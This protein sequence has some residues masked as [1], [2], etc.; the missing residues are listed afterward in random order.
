[1]YTILIPEPD[2]EIK[3]QL[4]D[5]CNG[6][7][8]QKSEKP[9]A[10]PSRYCRIS[11]PKGIYNIPYSEILFIESEQKKSIIHTADHA[12]SL[13]VPLYRLQETLPKNAFIQ[14]HR[15]FIINLENTAFID[16]TKDPWVI[17]FFRA[18]KTA[19]VSRTCQKKLLERIAPF[20]DCD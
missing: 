1:M 2:D 11:T 7:N 6:K 10:K 5:L 17:S 9:P 8:L 16:K 12:I 14:T 18:E 19:F 3:Q 4:Q 15:S 20:M 13:S